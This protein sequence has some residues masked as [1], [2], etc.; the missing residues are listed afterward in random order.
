MTHINVTHINVT[1]ITVTHITVTHH[2]F[3]V[4]TI[5]YYIL[6][7]IITTNAY[8]FTYWVFTVEEIKG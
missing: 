7:T 3:S 6:I 1:H 8:L 2:I 4:I 5:C